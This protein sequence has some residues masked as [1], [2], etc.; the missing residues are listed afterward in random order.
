MM[1]KYL[2]QKGYL[3]LNYV[4]RVSLSSVSGRELL[5]RHGLHMNVMRKNAM[6]WCTWAQHTWLYIHEV[7]DLIIQLDIEFDVMI[8]RKKDTDQATND[9]NTMD[10]VKLDLNLE[11]NEI[12]YEQTNKGK[13]K[14]SNNK[15]WQYFMELATKNEDKKDNLP[16]YHQNIKSLHGHKGEL[17]TMFLKIQSSSCIF[18]WTQCERQIIKFSLSGFNPAAMFCQNK[19]LKVEYVFWLGKIYETVD[20]I[21]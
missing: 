19:C 5:I 20:L 16:M 10:K 11:K 18:K 8:V 12:R 17:N 7:D 9:R 14:V 13:K 2:T 21:N 1:H 4:H 15:K 6:S 3:T